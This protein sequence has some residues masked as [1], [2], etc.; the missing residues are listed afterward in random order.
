MTPNTWR[1]PTGDVPTYI[2]EPS[3]SAACS[4]NPYYVDADS[5]IN[6]GTLDTPPAW[7]Y[8]LQGNRDI[9]GNDPDHQGGDVWVTNAAF[10]I[11]DH[12]TD[13]SGM[14]LTYGGIDKA[15]HMWGG[16]ND[17]PPYANADPSSHM[18]AMAKVADDQVGRVIDKL[19]TD[20]L[21]DETL[22]V[23]TT[24]HAQN[25]AVNYFGKD[26]QNRGNFNWYYGQDADE[27]YTQPQPE[28]QKLI[29]GTHDNV[30]MSMQDSAIRTWLKTTDRDAKV[31]AADVMKTLGG[32]RAVYVKDGDH[33]VKRWQA[34]RSAV[35]QPRV[36]L[37]PAA[38]PGDRRHPG[39]ALRA[40]RH[41]AARQRHQLRREGRPR[42]RP[43]VRAADPDRLL[44][45]RD[46]GR[47]DAG[48]P[49]A[50]GGHHADHPA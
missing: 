37:A 18:A 45:R 41:R 23:L 38:L 49:D 1:G 2:S 6:Y 44:R 14:L 22:V 13:W 24:D 34:P 17:V 43:G 20:G 10:D 25:T 16:L 27:N 31:Q 15:G 47:A 4:G 19:K 42:W 33:Y 26:G 5:D 12:E 30:A 7:M 40:R 39:G 36:R 28:I 46:Q 35:G 11:M 8:P 9:P 48:D 32:V 21:L 29:D 50:V 3:G